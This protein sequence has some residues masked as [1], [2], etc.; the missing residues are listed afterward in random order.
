MICVLGV[1][2]LFS[3]PNNSLEINPDSI[4]RRQILTEASGPNRVAI[5]DIVV[6][7]MTKVAA[8][9]LHKNISS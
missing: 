7:L 8:K 3:I 5:I 9:I 1:F 2:P 4:V 6:D